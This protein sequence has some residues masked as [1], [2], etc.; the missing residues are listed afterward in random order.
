M[1]NTPFRKQPRAH[2][3]G[4]CY[5][6]NGIVIDFTNHQVNSFG[7]MADGTS[8]NRL[9]D[10]P[11]SSLQ[12]CRAAQTSYGIYDEANSYNHEV[13]IAGRSFHFTSG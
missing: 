3:F 11:I 12:A 5:P 7:D 1:F 10:H 6:F 13:N 4:Q 8:I 2:I 9:L